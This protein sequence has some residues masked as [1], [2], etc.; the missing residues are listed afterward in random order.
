MESIARA[1]RWGVNGVGGRVIS[2]NGL[3]AN[4]DMAMMITTVV[5]AAVV[6]ARCRG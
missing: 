1:C 3:V 6:K 5:V 4:E 2:E